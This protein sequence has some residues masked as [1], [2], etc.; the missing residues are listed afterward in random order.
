MFIKR[1]MMMIKTIVVMMMMMMMTLMMM[2]ILYMSRTLVVS[3][4]RSIA[5]SISISVQ[6]VFRKT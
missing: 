5:T 1:M 6:K 4:F 3:H 2:M